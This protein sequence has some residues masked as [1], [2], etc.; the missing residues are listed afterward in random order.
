MAVRL[1]K[2]ACLYVC[3]M[4]FWAYD[5]SDMISPVQSR[6]AGT[7]NQY[8]IPGAEET[9]AGERLGAL[10]LQGSRGPE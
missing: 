8:R 3:T 2:Q 6:A 1:V 7:G 4:S 9:L 5:D 10:S